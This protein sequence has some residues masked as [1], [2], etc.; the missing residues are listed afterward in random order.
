MQ[1][2]AR[3]IEQFAQQR[4]ETLT[5]LS[6]EINQ[7]VYDIVRA[8]GQLNELARE[9]RIVE[10]NVKELLDALN[11]MTEDI[12]YLASVKARNRTVICRNSRP[13]ASAMRS[14]TSSVPQ[15][16]VHIMTSACRR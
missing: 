16:S 3:L 14:S 13:S 9:N 2:V 7:S 6:L 5:G 4:R 1:K 12:V 15:Q 8:S 11:S 10:T